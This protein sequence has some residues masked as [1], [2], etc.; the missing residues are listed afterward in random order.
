MIISLS[1]KEFKYAMVNR[2]HSIGTAPKQGFVRTEERPA[3]SSSHYDMARH[4]II[5]YDHRLTDEETKNFELA[6]ICDSE[7]M[8]EVAKHV[9]DRMKD[10]AEQ[11]IEMH[12]EEPKDFKEQVYMFLKKTAKGQVPSVGDD[13]KFCDTVEEIL[14]TYT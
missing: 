11:Y 10:Y 14:K 12:K 5:V 2:P 9:A 4:G 1:N 7:Q 6:L 8:K 13:D 3:K